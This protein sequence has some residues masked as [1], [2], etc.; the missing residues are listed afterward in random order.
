MIRIIALIA[1]FTLYA[2]SSLGIS[3]AHAQALTTSGNTPIEITADD[4][5]EWDR[6]NKT[7]TARTNA[8]A[9]QGTAAVA[10]DILRAEYREANGNDMQIWRFTSEGNV[11]LTSGDSKAYGDNA[12]YLMDEGLATMTGSDLRLNAPGQ[13]VT[14]RDKFEYY[15]AEGR[16]IA[17]GNAQITQRN[18]KGQTNTLRSDRMVAN[19]EDSPAGQRTLKTL[20]AFDN[21]VINTPTEILTGTYGI[22]NTASNSAEIKGNVKITRGPNILVGERAE[23]NLNTGISRLFG[24]PAAGENGR[25]RGVFYPGAQ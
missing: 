6:K 9:V 18:Q 17:T 14:A 12:V 8:K 7:F 1:A 2:Y 22:Y 3:T 20:E 13:N 21:V 11:V 24:D 23:V 10:G 4:S 19:L 5:L 16:L 25:V 15:V